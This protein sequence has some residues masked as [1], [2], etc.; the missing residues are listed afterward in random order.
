MLTHAHRRGFLTKPLV[1]HK[2]TK[3]VLLYV[4]VLSLYPIYISAHS[5]SLIAGLY[6]FTWLLVL[7]MQPRGPEGDSALSLSAFP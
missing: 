3:E 5:R 4:Y 2:L 1:L 6:L 7:E